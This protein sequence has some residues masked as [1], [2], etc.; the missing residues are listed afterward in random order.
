MARGCRKASSRARGR[1]TSDAVAAPPAH[2]ARLVAVRL[3]LDLAGDLPAA[4]FHFGMLGVILGHVLGLLIP[5]KWADAIG[6]SRHAYH[7]IALVGGIPAG[8]MAVVGLIILLYRRRTTGPVFSATTVNDKIMY[9]VLGVVIVLGIWNTI[10]QLAA[11]RRRVQLPRRGLAVALQRLRVPSGRGPDGGRAHRLQDPRG[12]GIP[13]HRAVA[14]HPIGARL[15]RTGRLSDP[16]LHRLSQPRRSPA[17]GGD[18]HPRRAPG[19]GP[20]WSPTPDGTAD[21]NPSTAADR[22]SRRLAAINR[23]K[24]TDGGRVC[25]PRQCVSFGPSGLSPAR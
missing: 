14:I 13:A 18:A 8:L 23:Q 17:G 11:V 6:L 5:Q 24:G 25:G 15:Q 21:E 22:R 4:L 19:T 3:A 2:R 12:G 7:V 9:L 1:T 10:A 16:A 20:V